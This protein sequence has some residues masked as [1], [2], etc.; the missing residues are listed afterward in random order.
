MAKLSVAFKGKTQ[1]SYSTKLELAFTVSDLHNGCERLPID[2]ARIPAR[3]A[4]PRLLND[5]VV[6]WCSSSIG[7]N[8][9]KSWRKLVHP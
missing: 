1:L 2:Q 4:H 3:A 6:I 5:I 7:N 9:T 8:T